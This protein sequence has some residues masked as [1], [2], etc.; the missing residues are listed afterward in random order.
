M[1]YS[2]ILIIS[3]THFPYEHPDTIPFLAKIQ[4]ELFRKNQKSSHGNDS[5]VIHIGDETDGA[6]WS[7][8]EK[9][10][11]L[12][13]SDQEHDHAVSKLKALYKLFP[14]TMVLESNHGALAKRKAN[15][16][17]I[18]T[19]WLKDYREALESPSGWSWH[20]SLQIDTP[21]RPFHFVHGYT[22]K[23]HIAVKH[24]G[25]SL[26]QGHHHSDLYAYKVYDPKLKDLLVAMQVGCL[27]NDKSPAFNYNNTTAKRPVIGC[28]VIYKGHAIPIPMYLDRNGRW[29]KTLKL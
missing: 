27:I 25:V 4:D 22:S 17:G 2:Y 8:H 10:V 3:D 19:K 28:G 14:K 9:S 21:T 18:P 29:V 23:A 16:S 12:F 5:L 20:P 6:A 26:V 24:M 1:T 7:Y 15:T 13:N 11:K